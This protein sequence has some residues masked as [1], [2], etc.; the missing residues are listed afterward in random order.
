[1]KKLALSAVFLVFCAAAV[2][3]DADFTGTWD[4]NYGP[5]T[6]IQKGKKATGT[7]YDGKA[8]LQGKVEG[9]KLTLNY[10]E[11]GEGGEAWFKLSEDGASFVGKYKT[12]GS[13]QWVEWNGTKK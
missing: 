7:Y 10:Q 9:R 8:T 1:M 11:P 5:V 3:A 6:M 2:H 4:T 13:D 12:A